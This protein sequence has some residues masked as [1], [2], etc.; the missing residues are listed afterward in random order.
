MKMSEFKSL[1]FIF[2]FSAAG[3]TLGYKIAPWIKI[4]IS[5]AEAGIAASRDTISTQNLELLDQAGRRRI[6][7]STTAAGAPAIWFFDQ[8]GKSRLN[9]GLYEDNNAFIVLNDNTEQAVQIFR[10]VGKKQAP[11]IVMKSQGQ[12]RIILGL[13]ENKTADPFFVYYDDKGT[14]KTV[15]GNYR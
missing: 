3:M 9:L 14:K 12:D 7:M 8:D 10:T 15:F 5:L 4:G 13:N 11:V 2:I 6:L 1:M